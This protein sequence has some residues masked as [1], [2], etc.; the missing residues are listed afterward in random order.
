MGGVFRGVRPGPL[1]G[2]LG[3]HDSP[4]EGFLSRKG[5]GPVLG[6]IS[7]GDGC[8]YL[9]GLRIKGWWFPPSRPEWFLKLFLR[10]TLRLPAGGCA[11]L[12]S[13]LGGFLSR[14]GAGPVL[15]GI[16]Y[17][18]GCC[19]YRGLRI[20][21]WWFPPSRPEWFLKLFLRDT[22]RLPAGGCAPLHSLLGGLLSG[23]GTGPVLRGISYGDGCCHYRGLRIGG[24]WFPPSRP[25]WFLKLFLRDT[26]RLP[27]EGQCPSALPFPHRLHGRRFDRCCVE[28]TMRGS[29][30]S[31]MVEEA[32]VDYEV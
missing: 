32:N 28:T 27:A 13:L 11:P 4:F 19:H 9:K 3:A 12:H 22:L 5:A 21:G 29:R 24:W 1:A 16:S 18:D 15:R 2:G 31:Q 17:G 26:L 30:S 8:H 14:K 6:G 20:G 25:E 7:Y 23:K 10:D